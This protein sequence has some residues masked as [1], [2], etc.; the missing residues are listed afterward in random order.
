MRRLAA[1]SF[2]L[3]LAAPALAQEAAIRKNLAERLPNFPKIDEVVKSPI[4]GLYEVRS[5]NEIDI[6]SGGSLLASQADIASSRSALVQNGPRNTAVVLFNFRNDTTQPLS[7]AQAQTALQ[8]ISTQLAA[9]QYPS[10]VDGTDPAWSRLTLAEFQQFRTDAGQFG[11][12]ALPAGEVALLTL[13]LDTAGV[14][15]PGGA[16]FAALLAQREAAGAAPA[17]EVALF[18]PLTGDIGLA[19][20]LLGSATTLSPSGNWLDIDMRQSPVVQGF[21]PEPGVA[22]LSL[23]AL[24]A[25]ACQRWRRGYI[26]RPNHHTLRPPAS[27]A[28]KA[29]AAANNALISVSRVSTTRRLD[30]PW[31]TCFR[32]SALPA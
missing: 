17:G 28:S 29:P 8:A 27:T 30:R 11:E 2:A 24:W 26:T 9:A 12:G 7:K 15:L 14:A 5:G 16:S 22:A 3:A 4:P 23:V 20:L 1:L 32:S 25:L 10:L 13:L 18:D 21:A 19:D 31:Q 6:T